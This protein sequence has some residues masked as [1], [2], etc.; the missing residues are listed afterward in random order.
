MPSFED[1]EVCWSK[2]KVTVTLNAK[3]VSADYLS[4]SS[5]FICRLVMTSRWSLFILGV[6]V[7]VTLMLKWFLLIILKKIF[8]FHILIGH[9]GVIRS[10]VNVTVT[11]NVR[12]F[13]AEYLV[14]YLLLYPHIF[15]T[16]VQCSSKSIWPRVM[17]LYMNVYQHV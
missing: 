7:I 15:L 8:I 16:C 3:I 17:K 11:L 6:I 13:S 4:K 5:Y 1:E 2:V 9:F 10:K 12:M 14:N